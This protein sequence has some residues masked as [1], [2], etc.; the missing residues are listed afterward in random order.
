MAQGILRSDALVGVKPGLD[1]GSMAD[2]ACN[3]PTIWHLAAFGAHGKPHA[4]I[5]LPIIML[6][7]FGSTQI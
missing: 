5:M 1:A 3:S 2:P 6:S 4:I 7:M